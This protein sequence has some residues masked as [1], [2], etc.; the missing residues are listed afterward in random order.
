MS[1]RIRIILAIVLCSGVAIA[2]VGTPLFFGARQTAQEAAVRE[3]NQLWG[4]VENVLEARIRTAETFTA[5]VSSMPRVKRGV[6]SNDRKGLQRLFSKDFSSFSEQTGIKQ[7]Q[8]HTPESVSMLRVHNPEKHGDDLSGFRAMVVAANGD[9]VPLS[10]L[11]RG[12]AGLG[13][14]A[15]HPVENRGE[16]VGTVEAGLALDETL[17]ARMVEDTDAALEFYLLPDPTIESFDPTQAAVRITAA[18]DGPALLDTEQ[19]EAATSGTAELNTLDIDGGTFTA[20]THVVTDFAGNAVAI[21]HILLP[22][23]HYVAIER[24]NM[25]RTAIAS[26]VALMVGA[27]MA[28]IVGRRLAGQLDRVVRRM[29]S[30]ADGQTDMTFDDLRGQ[31][32]EIAQMA[33]GLEVFRDG[34]IEADR[35]RVEEHRRQAEQE[36]VVA[37]LAEGL[38]ALSDGDLDARIDDD[39]GEGYARLVEDFNRAMSQLSE[40]ITDISDS[41]QS[42][43]TAA[44]QIGRA[45][46]DLSNRTEN[47]AA[48]LEQTSAA[49]QEITSAVREA[50]RGAQSADTSGKSAIQK[51]HSGRSVVASAVEA[52]NEVERASGEISQIIGLI[53]DIAFQ[54]NLLALNAGVEAARA[55]EAGSGFAV[56]AAEVRALAAR[57]TE[58][59]GRI[60]GLIDDSGEKVEHGVA[61]VGQTGNALSEIVTAIEDVTGQVGRIATLAAEQARSL[62]EINT[63]VAQL[64]AATQNNA[65]MFS[66]TAST[67]DSLLQEG[68]R[69]ATLVSRFNTARD[70]TQEMRAAG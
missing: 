43:N 41:S 24:A 18:Y 69:L 17:V 61:L 29:R 14:R 68:E 67:S 16:H 63:A 39:L 51:A 30:L 45:A 53:D 13:I 48:T 35:L 64:D 66:Q 46:N 9:R 49:L 28:W 56:V 62:D 44:T 59:A 54:T 34:L 15:I 8:F 33:E 60:G 47:S 5:M 19:L 6:D 70:A 12:R 25:Q 20:Q 40:L 32:R 2:C 65:G 31:G 23:A 7:F 21:A 22:R 50:T 55:G 4:R 27:V 52:I 37:R 58:A 36:A 10:G 57:T 3:M 11:E 38:R 26:A 42:V 1:L